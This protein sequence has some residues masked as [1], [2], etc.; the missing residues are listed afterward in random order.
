MGQQTRRGFLGQTVAAGA[1][2][3]ALGEAPSVHAA[4]SG[5]I[6]VG[7]IGCG[8]RGTGAA[9]QAMKTGPDVRLVAMGDMFQ[10]RLD[11]SRNL[12]KAQGGENFAVTDDRCFVGFDAYKKVI[13]SDVDVVLLAEPPHFRPEHLEAAVAAGKHIFAEKPVAV[14]APGVHRVEAACKEAERKKLCVVSG[15]MLHYEPSMQQ[16]VEQVHCG[17][18]GDIVSLQCNYNVGGLWVRPRESGWSDMEWHLRNWYYFTW[19]S[20]DHIVEQF[21]H[22]LDLIS[23]IMKGEYPVRAV[24]MGGRQSRV[25]PQFGHIFDHHAVVFEYA[26]GIRCHSYTRQQDGTAQDISNW[27]FGSNG[28]ANLMK[29]SITGEKS[30]SY[31]GP[32]GRTRSPGVWGGHQEEQDAL[33]DA[34]RKGKVINNG[35]YMCKSTLMAIMGRMATY[36][37][38]QI[39]WEQA[40]S[41]KEDL[42]PPAYAFGPLP[43][44]AVAVPGVTKFS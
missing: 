15:L 9:A 7:L 16:T 31:K 8:G 25:Q 11:S 32:T 30:W 21:V 38:Q 41:S 3:A 36:T 40:L 2:L 13:N 14:D 44:P 12:L 26:S 10:D 20:G 1:A 22:C 19:L 24:G 34:V 37:G 42:A 28:T 39:T 43:T 17:A 6:K 23:W 27:V 29:R 4:G 33:F 18:V 5:T 35:E